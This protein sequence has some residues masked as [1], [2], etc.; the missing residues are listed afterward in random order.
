MLQVKSLEK[1]P[2]FF[3]I[4]V[5]GRL[6]T[7]TYATLENQIKVVLPSANGIVLDM[8]PLEYISSMGLRVI[9]KATKDMKAKGVKID[10]PDLSLFQAKMGPAYEKIKKNIGEANFNKWMEMAK[11]TEA[12]K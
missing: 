8:G 10:T 5:V 2:G 7:S 11:A 6:D 4:T 9:F 3:E 12:K 1:K